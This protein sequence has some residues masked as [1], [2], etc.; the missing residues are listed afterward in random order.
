MMGAA[1]MQ[2]IDDTENQPYTVLIAEAPSFIIM[3]VADELS[4]NNVFECSVWVLHFYIYGFFNPPVVCTV[5]CISW[6]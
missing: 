3:A 5:I 6:Q 1:T 2:K 4:L